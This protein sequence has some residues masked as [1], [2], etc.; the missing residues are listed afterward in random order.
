[1]SRLV[2]EEY[3][4][5]LRKQLAVQR[6]DIQELNARVRAASTQIKARMAQDTKKLRERLRAVEEKVRKSLIA[7]GERTVAFCRGSSWVLMMAL[8][9]KWSEACTASGERCAPKGKQRVAR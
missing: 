8:T 4:A 6:A 9:G 2:Q 7:P 1:M 3:V 5:R